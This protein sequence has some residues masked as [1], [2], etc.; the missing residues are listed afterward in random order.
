MIRLARELRSR[1]QMETMMNRTPAYD[2]LEFGAAA[3]KLLTHRHELL[4][5]NLVNA[6]TP[7]FKARDI[8]FASELNRQ[9]NGVSVRG[10]LGLSIS[11][12]RHMR[13]AMDGENQ[14]SALYR[15]PV[16]PSVDGNTVDPDIERTHFMKN[17]W[18][19]EGTLSFLGS[20]IRTRLSAITGQPS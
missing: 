7:N 4:G 2:P 15:I 5:A 8:D 1:F 16:Q 20:T 12:A 9:M 17:A 10:E 3:L 6:D 18:M 14:P 19:T 11:N 13:L